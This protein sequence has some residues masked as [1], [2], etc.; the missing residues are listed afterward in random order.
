MPSCVQVFTSTLTH[1]IVSD[2]AFRKVRRVPVGTGVFTN[3]LNPPR[4]R[5]VT[6]PSNGRDFSAESLIRTGT[7]APR[8]RLAMRFSPDGQGR[9]GSP[10]SFISWAGSFIFL[11]VF[12]DS[13]RE[14]CPIL[15]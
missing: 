4:E 5:S 15:R 6:K 7:I 12:V 2:L 13:F 8:R 9:K 14:R 3:T 1:T 10:T 11:E